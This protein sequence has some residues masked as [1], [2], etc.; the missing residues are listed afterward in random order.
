ME[1]GTM[2]PQEKWV[3]S[4]FSTHLM[5]GKDHLC[6]GAPILWWC[7]NTPQKRIC[8]SSG[9][10]VPMSPPKSTVWLMDDINR[11]LNKVHPPKAT[12]TI[13]EARAVKELKRDWARTIFTADKGVTMVSIDR[14]DYI[15]K[16]QE[17][18]GDQYTY[19]P[20]SKDSTPR[21]KI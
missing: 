18:L 13:Q 20:I 17:L 10:S 12:I 2:T 7:L 16:A 3:I 21:L 14:Q 15:S 6:P 19:R 11:L 5:E 4:M 8:S 9:R 1:T